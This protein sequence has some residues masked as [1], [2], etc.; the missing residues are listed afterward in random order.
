MYPS[1]RTFTCYVK[2]H[3]A[4]INITKQSVLNTSAVKLYCTSCHPPPILNEQIS[5]R[6]KINTYMHTYIHTY[7]L[8]YIHTYLHK[9]C[10]G[11]R[12]VI[13]LS[14]CSNGG[15]SK[16]GRMAKRYH[17]CKVTEAL[18]EKPTKE[19]YLLY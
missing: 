13:F 5:Q 10:F 16:H 6:G 11:N 8:T 2:G 14:D 17:Q 15:A 1:H 7:M 19:F 12:G 9:G 18:K 4:I 3:R